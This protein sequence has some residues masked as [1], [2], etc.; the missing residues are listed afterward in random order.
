MCFV[1]RQA[2]FQLDL[3][4][5]STIKD[6]IESSLGCLSIISDKAQQQ[7][8]PLSLSR[9]AVAQSVERAT[10][11]EDVPGSIPAV[12]ARSLLV[13]SVSVKCDRL[14][15][16]PWSPSS[17]SCVAARKNCQKLC[18][19]ARPRYSLVVDEDVKKPTNQP[20][21]QANKVVV[22][23]SFK[24]EGECSKHKSTTHTKLWQLILNEPELKFQA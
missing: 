22:L 11:G 3:S 20:N 23:T 13:K 4:Y 1:H 9:G 24:K 21:K 2:H 10:S 8:T 6:K 16:K 5:P 12:A 14:R 15:Q 17:I 19:E 18:L 7:D